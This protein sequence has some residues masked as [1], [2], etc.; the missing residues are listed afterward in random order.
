MDNNIY[1]YI[2]VH[3]T[4]PSIFIIT[5]ISTLLKILQLEL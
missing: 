3:A 4:H 2:L 5:Y 1:Q